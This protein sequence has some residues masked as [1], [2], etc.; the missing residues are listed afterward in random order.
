MICHVTTVLLLALKEVGVSGG[1]TKSCDTF[2]ESAQIPS[3]FNLLQTAT[4]GTKYK[5]IRGEV[6]EWPGKL[7]TNTATTTD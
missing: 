4:Q 2:A 1:Q 3:G 7:C 6:E 5:V